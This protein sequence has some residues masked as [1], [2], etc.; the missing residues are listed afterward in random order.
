MKLT[1]RT[2]WTGGIVVAA[3]VV[4]F[5]LLSSVKDQLTVHLVDWNKK[6]VSASVTVQET[7]LYPVLGSMKF[8]PQWARVSTRTNDVNAMDGILKVRRVKK[9]GNDT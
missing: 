9:A 3:V 8:L 6:P 2:V 7:R 1:K 4:A 5:L